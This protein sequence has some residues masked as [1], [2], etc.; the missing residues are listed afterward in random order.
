MVQTLLKKA[1]QTDWIKE[2]NDC[3][4]KYFYFNEIKLYSS[5]ILI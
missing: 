1:L 2:Y 4:K 5:K 3:T